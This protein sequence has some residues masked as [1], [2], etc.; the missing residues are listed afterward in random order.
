MEGERWGLKLTSYLMPA[1]GPWHGSEGPIK[2]A[3]GAESYRKEQG[4]GGCLGPQK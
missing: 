2:P 3:R 1:L 4:E